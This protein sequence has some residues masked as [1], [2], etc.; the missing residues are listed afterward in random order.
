MYGIDLFDR[1]RMPLDWTLVY[2][3]INNDILSINI[4]HEFACRKLEHDEHMS[5]EEL[6]LTWTSK[7][8]QDVLELIERILSIH[9][10]VDESIEK[11]KDKICIAIIIYLRDTEKDIGRLLEQIDIIYADF[12]YP[13]DME[14]FITYMPS[15]DEY[16]PLKHKL[17]DN[18]YYLLSK[19][20]DFINEK[21]KEYQLERVM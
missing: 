17:E 12:G 8:R 13:E 18:R 11:A 1:I 21:M 16:N 7:N 2:Y 19:L 6:E 4:A 15:N 5:E 14:K 9:G 10:N 20:D 3:G